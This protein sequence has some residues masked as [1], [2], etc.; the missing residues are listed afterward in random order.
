MMD[1]KAK[2]PTDEEMLEEMERDTDAGAIQE[3]LNEE[4]DAKRKADRDKPGEG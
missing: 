4:E 3:E 2:E 1:G